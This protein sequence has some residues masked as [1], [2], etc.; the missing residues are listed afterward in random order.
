M[1][2]LISFPAGTDFDAKC[3]RCGGKVGNHPAPSST[4]ADKEASIHDRPTAQEIG[5]KA[6][7]VRAHVFGP[8]CR[9]LANPQMIFVDGVQYS[10]TLG[11]C[12]SLRNLGVI[13]GSIVARTV[14]TGKSTTRISGFNQS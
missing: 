7:L 9:R 11:E 4:L 14:R 13:K 8:E 10:L 5:P 3:P 6:I 1:N 12:L 2:C